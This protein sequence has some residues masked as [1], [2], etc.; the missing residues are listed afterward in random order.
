VL[1]PIIEAEKEDTIASE[2]PTEEASAPSEE[3][4]GEKQE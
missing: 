4:S 2:K 1:A 3:S